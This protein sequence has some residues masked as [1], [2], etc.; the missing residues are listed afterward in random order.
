MKERSKAAVLASFA[1]D[2]LALGA[3]WI[4]DTNQILKRF[5][6][7]ENLLGPSP[8]SY[9]PTKTKG[10]FTHYGDQM[11]VLLESLA[12]LQ[13]FD[14]RDFSERW[15][16]LFNG[17]EGYVDQATR[18]TLSRY[19]E[20]KTWRDPGS[21]SNDL[22]GAARIAPLVYL[23]AD[24]LGA[25]VASAREQTRMTHADQWTVESA[26]FF[27]RV[28]HAILHGQTPGD[29]ISDVVK[30][31]YT[32]SV[33]EKW[34]QQG[35]GSVERESVK[36]ILAFGQSCHAPEAFPG[37]IHL[38]EKYPDNLKEALV[39]GVMGGGDSAGRGMLAGLVLGAHNGMQG[40]PEAWI[41]G[42]RR[43]DHLLRLIEGI[44]PS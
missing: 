24:D 7:I 11:L 25:L 40:V 38:I 36:A 17:Y 34:V 37:V 32:G 14:L 3:H 6:R 41:T 18:M 12:D 10:D 31:H 28:V 22:A 23:Y 27:A 16:A 30:E 21:P 39:Q 26:E 8:D 19:A 1:G 44:L 20:G 2:A 29:A 33:I 35:R 42:M 9:H 13:R 4:Y 15:R 5:G 43:R